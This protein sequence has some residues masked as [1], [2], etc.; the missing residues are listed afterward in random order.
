M[1]NFFFGF[2]D[3]LLKLAQPI[4]AVRQRAA[5]AFGSLDQGLKQ[6]QQAPK[7]PAVN[8]PKLKPPGTTPVKPIRT[9][10]SKPPASLGMPKERSGMGEGEFFSRFAKPVKAKGDMD[11]S[12]AW[13]RLRKERGQRGLPAPAPTARDDLKTLGMKPH[14]DTGRANQAAEAATKKTLGG[15]MSAKDIVSQYAMGE[16][17]KRRPRKAELTPE[18]QRQQ[19]IQ[20]QLKEGPKLERGG[21]QVPA[22]PMWVRQGQKQLPTGTVQSLGRRARAQTVGKQINYPLSRSLISSATPQKPGGPAA[23]HAARQRSIKQRSI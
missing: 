6:R 1:S 20:A 18:Q 8:P 4:A 2:G 16:K 5:G 12:A 10:A 3:E 11:S 17:R 13:K 15:K 14:R 21:G 7:P 22:S 23:A 9:G 19:K